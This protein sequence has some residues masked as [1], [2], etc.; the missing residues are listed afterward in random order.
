MSL[1]KF[2]EDD[3]HEWW[4]VEDPVLKRRVVEVRS[5]WGALLDCE[6]AAQDRPLNIRD[7]SV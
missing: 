6:S 2:Y 4:V 3:I 5:K 1:G 7:R